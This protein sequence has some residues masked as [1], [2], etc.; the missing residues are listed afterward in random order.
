[1]K[2][3]LQWLRGTL[4]SKSLP[5]PGTEPAPAPSPASGPP[6]VPP[7][8]PVTRPDYKDPR[9]LELAGQ[10]AMGDITA[11]WE[12]AQWFR[13]CLRPSTQALLDQYDSGID[14][15]SELSLRTHYNSPDHFPLKAYVTWLNQ[16]ARYGHA[17]AGQ[18]TADRY[19][20]RYC[21]VLKEVTHKVGNFG[22]ELYYGSDLHNL[23]LLDVDSGFFE[24]GLHALQPEG[25]FIAY[26]LADYIPADSDGFG[27]EDEYANIFYDEFFNLIPGKTLDDARRNLPKLLKKREAYWADPKHDREH[28]MYRRLHAKNT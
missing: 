19:F 28:R 22:S 4:P 14:C 20:Y 11:M 12:L 15:Y 7:P 8:E 1:M 13:G 23:G 2:N 25:I 9:Y 10:C 27:R 26:Y 21:G 5:K 24:F 18:I 16:A 17:R 6:P 3:L